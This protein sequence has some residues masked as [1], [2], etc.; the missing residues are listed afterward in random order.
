MQDIQLIAHWAF[1]ATQDSYAPQAKRTVS[2]DSVGRAPVS[3]EKSKHG[4]RRGK[5][6]SVHA[7][8]I[9]RLDFSGVGPSS[10]NSTR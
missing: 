1:S 6:G 4:G 8:V 10:Y 5:K 3:Q 9:D 7:D 2:Q